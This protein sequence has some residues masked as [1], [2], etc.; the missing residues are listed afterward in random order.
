LQGSGVIGEVPVAAQPLKFIMNN[1]LGKYL[2]IQIFSIFFSAL[3]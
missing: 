2:Q 1:V 3:E